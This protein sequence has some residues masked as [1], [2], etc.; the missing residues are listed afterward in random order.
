MNNAVLPAPVLAVSV[1]RLEERM[2]GSTTYET[3]SYSP[4][5]A[6]ADLSTVRTSMVA[7]YSAWLSGGGIL[8]P[9]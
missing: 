2:N 6:A 7:L 3:G 9:R 8:S 1:Y 4:Q 5:N